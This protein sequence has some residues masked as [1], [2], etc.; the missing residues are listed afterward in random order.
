MVIE[1]AVGGLID[2]EL[3][4]YEIGWL[5]S[6]AAAGRTPNSA[7][8]PASAAASAE[9]DHPARPLRF[10]RSALRIISRYT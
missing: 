3:Y 7:A 10:N 5:S 2:T 6:T 8:Q 1:L 4:K 9:C